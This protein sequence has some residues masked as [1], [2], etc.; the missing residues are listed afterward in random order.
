MMISLRCGPP[1][2]FGEFGLACDLEGWLQVIASMRVEIL[3]SGANYEND[4]GIADKRN[5]PAQRGR[6][7]LRFKPDRFYF[8]RSC[9]QGF[10][11]LRLRWAELTKGSVKRSL[12]EWPAKGWGQQGSV[13]HHVHGLRRRRCG[14][15]A[16]HFGTIAARPMK[17]AAG[18]NS[19]TKEMPS[20]AARPSQRRCP[21]S[22]RFAGHGGLIRDTHRSRRRLTQRS[23]IPRR[24]F[25]SALALQMLYI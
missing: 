9:R 17:A 20:W 22:G 4:G 7:F 2:L 14:T 24:L 11:L 12:I 23:D 1:C 18:E 3:G 13:C 15:P 19:R 16:R 10:C 25:G 21:S 5:G 6:L 8:R